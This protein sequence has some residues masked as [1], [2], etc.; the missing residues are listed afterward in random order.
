MTSDKDMAV[1]VALLLQQVAAALDDAFK[2][3]VG[4]RVPFALVVQTAGSAQYVSNGDRDE[5]MKLLE[6]LLERAKAGKADIPAWCN[7]EILK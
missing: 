7:P 1:K 2:D 6:E 5:F 4:H 3:S